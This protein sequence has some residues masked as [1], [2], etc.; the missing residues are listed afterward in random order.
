M[1][2]EASRT[3][4]APENEA[5]A[6]LRQQ[7]RNLRLEL[8]A[9]ASE[10]R[11]AMDQQAATSAILHLI[12]TFPS[13][14]QPIFDSIIR[15]ATTLCGA[16][17]G[18]VLRFD[19]SLIHL[20]ADSGFA[21]EEGAS[22][23]PSFPLPPDRASATGRAILTRQ[24]VHVHDIMADPEYAIPGIV[25]SGQRTILSVPMLRNAEPIGAITVVRREV[26]PFSE[27]EIGLLETFADQAAIAIENVRLVDELRQREAELRVTLDNM[28]DG[29]AMFDVEFRIAAW[30]RNFQQILDL[31]DAFLA[32][33]PSFAEYFEYLRVR[34]E[35]GSADLEAHLRRGVDDTG[36]EMRFE[37]TRPDGRILEVRRTGVPGGGFVLI[38]GDVTERRRAEEEI[39]AA[40]DALARQHEQDRRYLEW[41]RSLATFLRHE[42][43]QPVA[44]ITSSIELAQLTSAQGSAIAPHLSNAAIGAQHVLSLIERASRA[45]DAEAFVRQEQPRQLDLSRLVADVVNRIRRTLSGLDVH[46]FTTEGPLYAQ[47]DPTL[48]A[49]AIGNLLSNAVSFAR[50]ESVI[51]I[52]LGRDGT[53]ALIEVE[54]QGPGLPDNV[55]E[56][57]GPFSSTRAEPSSEH[58]GLGL[59]LVRLIAEHYG[60]QASLANLQDG[61]GV[62]AAIRLPL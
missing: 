62:R 20:V 19:G 57:F 28:G 33:R 55:E 11:V 58:Q 12:S 15:N 54:N 53:A 61:S 14:L 40:R 22:I 46:L 34:G 43:R 25:R 8:E 18:G 56:L 30:N 48:I 49:E 27:T 26:R 41:L 21:S 51:E 7:L 42:V 37:R 3:K 60:G 6:L 4:S 52:R 9:R 47:V 1:S 45:T 29:V 23:R 38:V 39:R 17:G 35:Y 5:V 59:Y 13:N 31:P 44:Q 36:R 10:L 2:E 50:E 24:V 32:E 16:V